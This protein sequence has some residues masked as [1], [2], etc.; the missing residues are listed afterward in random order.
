[1]L[2]AYSQFSGKGGAHIPVDYAIP[3]DGMTLGATDAAV[4]LMEY[5]DYR[6]IHCADF[7]V[8][9]APQMIQD[10]LEGGTLR[11]EFRPMPILGGVAVDDPANP[12]VL[13]EE[14]ALRAA[15]QGS[16]WPYHD[17]LMADTQQGKALGEEAFR[18]AASAS[19]LDP[20]A[21]MTCVNAGTHR[22]AVID[23]YTQATAQG[24]TSTPTL[25]LQGAQITWTGDYDVLKKQIEAARDR[26]R[27][28]N[29]LRQT[30][31]FRSAARSR[32]SG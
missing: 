28:S 31:R 20:D 26:L 19:G 1:M 2:W 7:A 12:S 6:C 17:R 23:S 32:I 25:Y 10:F 13:A 11:Y 29:E 24:I 27:A 21:L 15:D 4:I 3:S 9:D 5:G 14:S 30:R 22:Q 18:A 16:F 8:E